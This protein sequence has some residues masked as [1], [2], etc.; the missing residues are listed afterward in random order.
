MTMAARILT[1]ARGSSGIVQFGGRE[2]VGRCGA[3]MVA[4][5]RAHP[6]MPRRRKS[7]SPVRASGGSASPRTARRRASYCATTMD[8]STNCCWG[9][10]SG[11]FFSDDR[12]L[13]RP[14]V[15]VEAEF[16]PNQLREFA[17]SHGLA[18]NELLLDECQCL[19]SKFMRTTRTAFPRHQSSNT[20]FVEAGLGLVVRRP[21]NPV[22]LGGGAHLSTETRRSISYLT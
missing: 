10:S 6:H 18:R 3:H 17:R 21:R 8:G 12:S 15:D 14:G 5:A 11:S 4:T 13:D 20:A 1:T 19:A 7:S 16:L 9:C 2:T 22:V